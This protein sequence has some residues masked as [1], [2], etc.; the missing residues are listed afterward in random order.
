MCENLKADVV[1]VSVVKPDDVTQGHVHL[2]IQP[3]LKEFVNLAQKSYRLCY[4]LCDIFSIIL[5][6]WSVLHYITELATLSDE[7]V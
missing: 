6:L 1:H 2:E 3:L 4:L 7:P 5:I